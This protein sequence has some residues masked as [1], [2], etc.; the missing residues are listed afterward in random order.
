MTLHVLHLS[1]P[2]RRCSDLVKMLR[3]ARRLGAERPGLVRTTFLG[4]HAL[5]LEFEG[6]ADAYIDLVVNEALPAIAA[7]GLADAVD[8]FCE[9]IGFPTEQ[10]VR[11]FAAEH[12]IGQVGDTE[13]RDTV[14]QYV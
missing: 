6:R 5:P 11:V 9:G 4:A 1:V 10:T 12:A 8:A 7:E 14:C 3:A 13:H 2:T